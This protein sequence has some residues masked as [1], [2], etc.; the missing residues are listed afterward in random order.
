MSRGWEDV[1]ELSEMDDVA[2]LGLSRFFDTMLSVGAGTGPV[3]G[4]VS[5]PP[6]SRTFKNEGEPS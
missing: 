1:V 3:L 2:A 5:E 6:L 4:W